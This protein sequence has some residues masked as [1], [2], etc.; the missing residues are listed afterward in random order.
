MYKIVYRYLLGLLF[1]ALTT[2]VFAQDVVISGVVT[3]KDTGITIPG[4]T[5]Q[6]KGST[7]GTVADFDGNYTLAVSSEDSTL[8]VSFVGYKTAE[9][10]IAGQSIINVALET[11]LTQLS[12]VVVIGYGTQ[13]K[14]VVT[15]A[16]ASVS[17]EEITSTP[18]VRVDQALQGRTPGVQVTNLS[19]QPGEAPTV[20]IRGAGTT[21][22]SAPLYIVDGLQVD[23]IEYLNPGVSRV[24]MC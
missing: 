1:L 15:G 3:E 24:W 21:G 6:V 7:N 16:I 17:A 23:N 18:V 11:S 14:K 22:N 20:I 13:K 5:I 9:I 19:G 10:Q 4:A 2:Q 12:E 8:I